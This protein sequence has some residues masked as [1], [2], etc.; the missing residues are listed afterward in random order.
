MSSSTANEDEVEFTL[1]NK[2]QAKAYQ[3]PPSTSAAGQRAEEWKESIWIGRCRLVGKGRTLIIR[4]L[5]ADND[6][7]FAQCVIPNGDHEKYVERTVDSSRYFVLKIMNDQ[8]HAFIGFG[9]SDRNDAFDFVSALSDF[10]AK[11][12]EPEVNNDSSWKIQVPAQDLSLKEGQTITINLKGLGGSQRRSEAEKPGGSGPV[13]FLA[14]PPQVERS[15]PKPTGP[16]SSSA[17]SESKAKP[18]TFQPV[19]PREGGNERSGGRSAASENFADFQGFQSAPAVQAWNEEDKKPG[20][21][22]GQ[23]SFAEYFLPTFLFTSCMA[24]TRTAD[25]RF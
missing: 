13:P 5:D 6:S 14:P 12:V 1:L 23:K 7:L 25:H 24:D 15:A 4:F 22:A 20:T 17:E 10:K 9:F 11:Y 21:T 2:R 16:L 8:R 3:I 18:G 19:P